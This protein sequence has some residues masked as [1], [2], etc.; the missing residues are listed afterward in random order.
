MVHA[1]YC[2]LDASFLCVH[3]MQY[4]HLL[5]LT[6]YK[7][8]LPMILNFLSV[9]DSVLGLVFICAREQLLSSWKLKNTDRFLGT[10]FKAM[11]QFMFSFVILCCSVNFLT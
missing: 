2:N 5:C 6:N 1:Y 11:V 9:C 7:S 10:F 3:E 4:C 8:L